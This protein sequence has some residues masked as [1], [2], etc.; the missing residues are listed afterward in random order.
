LVLETDALFVG[1]FLTA[2]PISVL[3]TVSLPEAVGFMA[4]RGIGNLIVNTDEGKLLGI[5]TER[6]I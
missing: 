5:L 3:D 1:N 4:R 2:F 6:D